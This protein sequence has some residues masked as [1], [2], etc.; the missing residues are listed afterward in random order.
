[1]SA[2]AGAGERAG[3]GPVPVPGPG[4]GSGSGHPPATASARLARD[5]R[6]ESRGLRLAVFFA[7][8]EY[9]SLQY[10]TLLLHAPAGRVLGAA[11]I[12][13][14][15]GGVLSLGLGRLRRP[16]WAAGGAALAL[17]VALAASLLTLGIPAHLLLHWGALGDDLSRGLQ[18]LEGWLWPFRGEQ[19]WPRLAVLAL[20]PP[21]LLLAAGLCFWPSQWRRAARELLALALLLALTLAGVV[22]QHE[23]A[24]HVQGLALALLVIAWLWLPALGTR[25]RHGVQSPPAHAGAW[26][27]AA[28]VGALVLAPLLSSGTPWL[29]YRAWDPVAPAVGFDWNQTYGPI[30]WSRSPA[31]MLSVSEPT[32]E[33]LRITTLDRFDGARFVRSAQPPGSQAL[34]LGGRAGKDLTALQPTR[35]PAGAV[36][37]HATIS[38]SG[39]RSRLLVGGGGLITEVQWLSGHPPLMRR[40]ADGTLELASVPGSGVR[41]RVSSYIAGASP[42][43]LRLTSR[44]YPREY[45][46]YASFS[47]PPTG[48][49]SPVRTVTPPAPGVAPAS[50]ASL[51]GAIEASPYAR[52]FT[53]ARTLAQGAGS[54]YEVV[55]RVDRFLLTHYRYNERPPASAYPLETFLF[56]TAGGYCQQFS[57]AMALLLRMD[58]IPARIAAGFEPTV[59]DEATG[60][61]VV[62]ALDAHSWVEVYFA[63]VGWVP[64]DPTPPAQIQGLDPIHSQLSETVRPAG[65]RSSETPRRAVRASTPG[66]ARAGASGT[67]AGGSGGIGWGVPAL[68]ALAAVLLGLAAWRVRV[69]ARRLRAGL[70]GDAA[71]AV[72]EVGAALARLDAAAW[73]LPGGGPPV[74]LGRLARTLEERDQTSA[75]AYVRALARARF[76]GAP[77]AGA[78]TTVN[79]S[80]AAAVGAG[81][82][83]PRPTLRGR[84]A[85]R[86]ALAAGRG[87]RAR[88]RALLALPPGFARRA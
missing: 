27:L 4:P 47:L 64:F 22:N 48:A 74:T 75:A 17:V 20:L 77:A 83:A 8:A 87:A 49:G 40:A 78:D 81:P 19:R 80:R 68:L 43:L 62:R 76:S 11:A 72:A 54:S 13:T 36:V 18:G 9:A 3:L 32:P 63:G 7:F 39:L 41:Y 53:L 84:R 57:G 31:A 26:L 33:L 73:L 14:A 79:A 38:L 46:P 25:E 58:G 69:G 85:L 24:W 2:I 29:D 65:G 42:A 15:C 70:G 34:D 56:G 88:V 50:V 71:G 82:G 12:A 66:R 60:E 86:E 52:A 5:R 21:S 67:H 37:Q 16:L 59:F 28:V 61:W 35:I 30:V 44:S 1:V 55:E 10:A 6:A 45:L 23:P 51:A